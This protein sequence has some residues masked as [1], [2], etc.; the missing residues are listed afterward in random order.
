MTQ[1][2]ALLPRFL[3]AVPLRGA[4]VT[5]RRDALHFRWEADT[6]C[7][8]R[9]T[10]NA[11]G[12]VALPGPRHR[13]LHLRLDLAGDSAITLR[14]RLRGDGWLPA[15]TELWTDHRVAPGSSEIAIDTTEFRLCQKSGNADFLLLEWTAPFA[16][17]ITVTELWLVEQSAEED[18]QP[19]V[20]RFG[21]RLRGEWPGKI[22]SDAPLREDA[23]GA[24]PEPMPG[25]DRFGGWQ[26]GP[27]SDASGFFRTEKRDGTWWL[28][29]PKGAPF[30]SF[31]PCCVSPGTIRTETRGR[32]HCFAELPPKE[33]IFLNAWQGAQPGKRL[34]AEMHTRAS[35]GG[36]PESTVVNF[37]IA[38]LIR[39]WGDDWFAKWSSET[40]ARLR[41]WGMNTLACWSD[42]ELA[43]SARMPYC[44]MADRVCPPPFSKLLAGEDGGI[45]P[46][47]NIPDVFHPDFQELACGWFKDLEPYASDPFLLGYFVGNEEAWC[48]WQSPFS[49][50]EHWE[51]RKVFISELEKHYNSIQALNDAWHTAF[52]DFK[53]M[54]AFQ[55]AENPPGLSPQGLADCDGFLRRFADRYFGTV[56]REL[57][58]ADPNHLFL[59]CRYLALPPRPCLLEGAAAHMDVVSIN[60]YLWH[61]QEPDDAAAFLG[62]WHRLCGAKPLIISEYAFTA[63]DE[64]LLACHRPHFNQTERA[65]ITAEFTRNCQKLPF[66]IG[67]HWFQYIDQP[68]TGRTLSDG[69]RGNFGLVDVADRPYPKVVAALQKCG[70]AL[71]AR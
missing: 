40:L 30:L 53:Q 25:R 69:E 3:Y 64:R 61:K 55:Q 39:K 42:L 63:T 34:E 22:H 44:L 11:E 10:P 9:I 68:I 56:R 48:A 32:E 2:T 29:T 62:E 23:A 47:N 66:V 46:L 28:I 24:Q 59:G 36:D 20:D 27:K 54:A 18:F 5:H 16:G 14:T 7:A 33:G 65:A 1:K 52:L 45:F 13:A 4:E 15:H 38:N 26:D 58:A 57:R 70:S 17:E 19:L 50:P 37:A 8:V 31:G 21:Q 6:A 41:H 12:D 67:M 71:Y 35:Y 43:G 51:S 60:W 49:L